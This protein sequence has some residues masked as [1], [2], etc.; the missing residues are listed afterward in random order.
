MGGKRL[1][2][3]M[4]YELMGQKDEA[5]KILNGLQ[6]LP[7]Q[8]YVSPTA[9]IMLYTGLGEKDQAFEWLDKACEER[10]FDLRML[11]VDPNLDTLRPDPRFKKVVERVGL[12]Q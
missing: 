12:S 5:R 1:V 6:E 4:T 11:N 9:F 7:K 3:G 2:L 8:H 10:D